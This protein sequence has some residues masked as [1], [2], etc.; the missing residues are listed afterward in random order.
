M[1]QTNWEDIARDVFNR[2]MVE[3][4]RQQRDGWPRVMLVPTGALAVGREFSIRPR[5]IPFR[6]GT[7]HRDVHALGEDDRNTP[8]QLSAPARISLH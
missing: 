1:Q 4:F 5:W 2:P 7:D 8:E 3:L 6:C